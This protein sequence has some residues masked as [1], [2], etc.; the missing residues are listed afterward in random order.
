M[1]DIDSFFDILKEVCDELPDE[2]FRELH[3]G[4]QLAEE[5][6]ISPYARDGD[7]VIMGEYHRS[8]LGNK[9]TIYYGSF[10]RTCAGMTD[11]EL[12]DRLREVVRHEFRHHMEN[13][14]GM[15]GRDSLEHEDREELRRYL[16]RG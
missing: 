7:L 9:I 3:H 4:V 5:L 8:Y 2:F 10:A 15:Y 12:K 11:E 1:T 14:S 6:K 13:L 16:R